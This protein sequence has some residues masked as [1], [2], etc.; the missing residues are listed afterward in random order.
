MFDLFRNHEFVHLWSCPTKMIQTSHCLLGCVS[1][2]LSRFAL[3]GPIHNVRCYQYTNLYS[4]NNNIES[5]NFSL[6][7]LQRL[8]K[9]KHFYW[10]M[11]K[12]CVLII[13]NENE[14]CVI[15]IYFFF[16]IGITTENVI[17]VTWAGL[18]K[19]PKVRIQ[20]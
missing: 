1:P 16:L 18:F 10:E 11:W 17:K 13:L 8:R 3:S 9:L 12:S 19:L 6:F 2:L 7:K 5:K 20:T 14:T 4:R 15:I